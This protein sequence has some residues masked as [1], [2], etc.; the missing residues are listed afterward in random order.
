ME[1][2]RCFSVSVPDD[3]SG[4][5][6]TTS[7]SDVVIEE[8]MPLPPQLQ[9]C[10]RVPYLE[11]VCHSQFIDLT[12]SED[13]PRLMGKGGAACSTSSATPRKHVDSNVIDLTS[14][15]EQDD[16]LR[17]YWPRHQSTPYP[18]VEMPPAPAEEPVPEAS[19]PKITL[20][21]ISGSPMVNIDNR[22]IFHST[23]HK[24]DKDGKPEASACDHETADCMAGDSDSSDYDS[25]GASDEDGILFAT[26]SEDEE[27]MLDDS[28]A[29]DQE[30]DV[31]SHRP[32][33]WVPDDPDDDDDAEE[34]GEDDEGKCMY[35]TK[36]FNVG[37]Y[38]ILTIVFQDPESI[39]Y[40]ASLVSSIDTS[41]ED[42]LSP[43]V[44]LDHADLN[45]SRSHSPRP[46]LQTS[47]G[48]PSSAASSTSALG[49]VASV[50][51]DHKGLAPEHPV[52]TLTDPT[53][54]FGVTPR[55]LTRPR[56]PSPSDAAMVKATPFNKPERTTATARTL[57][58][59]TGKHEF[60]AAREDN[61]AMFMNQSQPHLTKT[62]SENLAGHRD[63]RQ[64]SSKQSAAGHL[65]PP[66]DHAKA[67]TDPVEFYTQELRD[68]ESGAHATAPTGN[69][70]AGPA[71]YCTR[72]LRDLK[73]HVL[74][75][76]LSTSGHK[77][78]NSPDAVT[79]VQSTCK[80]EVAPPDLDM[81]SAFM[82][83]R[84]KKEN[85]TVS[86]IKRVPIEDLLAH[87]P[88]AG[89]AT[90]SS[91]NKRAFDDAFSELENISS[92]EVAQPSG[93]SPGNNAT[94][95]IGVEPS[96]SQRDSTI[97][98]QASV[99][100]ANENPTSVSST[101]SRPE[102]RRRYAEVAAC[103]AFGGVGVLSALILSA[104]SF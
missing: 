82:F 100:S 56:L 27:S 10:S 84:S 45:G 31:N 40:E 8:G 65:F 22:L 7:D 81:S 88:A 87:E 54:N 102:K 17:E 60:F 30:S 16:T 101:A 12:S 71:N 18:E 46:P 14:E 11:A 2:T 63:T 92:D 44:G 49:T 35:T 61:K 75:C 66:A 83:Q 53:H 97:L 3:D 19:A 33:R 64:N 104:P 79:P 76:A 57:A 95:N 62:V 99:A 34:D 52:K 85:E 13:E 47:S 6:D 73:S 77:F 43:D 58:E 32:R 94:V 55:M 51:A 59:K 67:M 37:L 39:R 103:V 78:I 86:N 89:V 26:F 38:F 69:A 80:P 41:M 50:V 29:S 21:S 28:A 48:S 96:L 15:P 72:E 36:P 5:E 1:N 90:S 24:A 93:P 20:D 98:G 4:D 91:S 68:F 25:I 23:P 9:Q 70:F 74:E 42:R